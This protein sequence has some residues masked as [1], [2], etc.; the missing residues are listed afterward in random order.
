MIITRIRLLGSILGIAIAIH[1]WLQ[2]ERGFS[3]GCFG[4]N[5]NWEAAFTGC[6]DP[7]LNK[8]SMVA[9][10][11]TAAI[12]VYY[13][14]ATALALAGVLVFSRKLAPKFRFAEQMLSAAGIV[15][16]LL[17]LGFQ[18]WNNRYCPLCVICGALTIAL[19]SLGCREWFCPA[20]DEDERIR[21]TDRDSV[22]FAAVA[23]AVIIPMIV[24]FSVGRPQRA[25]PTVASFGGRDIEVTVGR[26]LSQLIKPR[27]LEEMA[28]KR[29]AEIFTLNTKPWID[30]ATPAIGNKEGP[31]VVAFLDPNCPHCDKAF[32]LMM[33]LAEKYKEK[34]AFYVIA[35]PLWSHSLAQVEALEIVE[36]PENYFRLWTL[37][38][39]HRK[40]GG[41]DRAEVERL[42]MK[43]GVD[44]SNLASRLEAARVNVLAKRRAAERAGINSTP[45][46]FVN[47][48]SRPDFSSNDAAL[49]AV[50]EEAIATEKLVRAG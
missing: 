20:P 30:Q 11:S 15:P 17:L 3:E 33:R 8:L 6:K 32:E 13:Y 27:A 19:F 2:K 14:A 46:I 36:E 26:A 40:P 39:E 47:G 45:A 35:R 38:F 4:L 24:A 50:I 16:T 34:A 22:M 7:V 10:V 29:G 31:T 42:L 49:A 18:V 12:A 1:L 44:R 37:Q 41:M 28:T 48:V 5:S 43:V 25:Q 21:A 9:G 23:C